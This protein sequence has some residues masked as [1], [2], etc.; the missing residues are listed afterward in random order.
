MDIL[1]LWVIEGSEKNVALS[2]R[3]TDADE[4]SLSIH[5]DLNHTIAIALVSPRSN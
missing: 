1:V 2:P 5:N 4:Y 3:L